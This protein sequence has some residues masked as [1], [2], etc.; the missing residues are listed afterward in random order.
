MSKIETIKIA[1]IHVPEDRLRAVKP[2]YAS[3]MAM[4]IEGGRILPPIK[5]RRTPNGKG[6]KFTLV[7]G[8]HRLEGHRLAGRTEI[9]AVIKKGN[10]EEAREEEVEENLFRN[11]LTALE[12]IDAVAAYRDIFEARH[13]EIR[14]G[15]PEF[16]NSAN[17]AE[18]NLL[19][20]VEDSQ[21][22]H[23]YSRVT[24]RLGIAERS[25]RRMHAIA[26]SL[27]RELHDAITGTPVE[28]N[29]S[30][31]ERLSKLPPSDQAKYAVLL[32][33]NGGD[34]DAADAALHPK[35]KQSAADKLQSRLIDT[36]GR[37]KTKA[38]VEFVREYRSDIEAALAVLDGEAKKAA[39]PKPDPRQIDIEDFAKADPS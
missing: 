3:L 23:F 35:P 12:R 33:D 34:L 10:A 25:A 39:A 2:D 11:E 30:A 38:H 37:M 14:R 15:N 24:L 26:R 8:G 22:G 16:S 29:Q 21:E 19:G 28:D 17:L 1:D 6:G 32:A 9:D 27:N 20:I 31:I 4:L 7:V 36:W 5:V 13:G 18:L